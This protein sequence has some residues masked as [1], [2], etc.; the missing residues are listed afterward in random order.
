MEHNSSPPESESPNLFR[1][2]G[3][4]FVVLSALVFIVFLEENWRGRMAWQKYQREQAARG[5]P[6]TWSSKQA[7]VSDSQNFIQ[8][9]VLLDAGIRHEGE[10]NVRSQLFQALPLKVA[11]RGSDEWTEG[12][13][14]NLEKLQHSLHAD[15]AF[16]PGA[17]AK[18]PADE[19][20]A[21]F[22][23]AEPLMEEIR[24][25]AKLPYSQFPIAS[26]NAFTAPM[27]KFVVIRNLSQMFSLHASAALAAGKTN[28]A[29]LDVWVINQLVN[30]LEGQPTLVSSM[31][32]VAV[33]RVALQPFWEGLALGNWGE[34]ELQQFQKYFE[35]VKLMENVHYSLAA[36]ERG[37]VNQLVDQTRKGKP[38]LGPLNSKAYSILPSGWIYQNQLTYN[39]LMD[40]ATEAY[41]PVSR[42]FSP[43]KVDDFQTAFAGLLT[44]PGPFHLLSSMAMPNMSKAFQSAIQTEAYFAQAGTACALE[45]YRRQHRSFPET[46]EALV[47]KFLEKIPVDP[48][49]GEPM[50]YQKLSDGQY[51][52]Y[53]I[54]WNETDDQ[55]QSSEKKTDGDWVWPFPQE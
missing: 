13:M 38:S 51:K 22:G 29:F 50:R 20:L 25:A 8:I 23:E 32:R 7:P 48:I 3:I 19:I 2:A 10:A 1:K 15:A 44:R 45:R 35:K 18:S 36:G 24:E 39:R 49:G 26:E 37:A 16:V 5:K 30:S 9:P 31:V 52:L 54:G 43:K 41:D 6:L 40:R 47:P 12:R 14:R 33:A 42:R 27:P 11:G 4:V 17:E 34:S 53:S 21:L 55:G 28:Q 46:L